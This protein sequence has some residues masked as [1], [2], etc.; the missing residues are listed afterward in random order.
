MDLFPEE[1][2]TIYSKSGKGVVTSLGTLS[3]HLQPRSGT[4]AKGMAPKYPTADMF[5]FY[6]YG[7]PP[8]AVLN[9]Y[10]LVRADATRRYE[11]IGIET[12]VASNDYMGFA[13]QSLPNKPAVTP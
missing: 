4:L 1:G 5:A 13:L 12:W 10:E 2:C 9:G 7:L 6:L 11:I 3:L 8:I